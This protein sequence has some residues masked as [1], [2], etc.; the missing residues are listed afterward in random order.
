[1]G[2][3]SD[4]WEEKTAITQ[5]EIIN[6]LTFLTDSNDEQRRMRFIKELGSDFL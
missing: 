4:N 1:M 6:L 2:T 3:F 5:V